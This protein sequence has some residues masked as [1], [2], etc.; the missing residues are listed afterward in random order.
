M[1][2][3]QGSQ[4]CDPRVWPLLTTDR[5]VESEAD[6]EQKD[7]STRKLPYRNTSVHKV[8]RYNTALQTPEGAIS[9]QRSG[10]TFPGSWNA[11]AWAVMGLTT[12]LHGASLLSCV[13]LL[14]PVTKIRTMM[15]LA[16]LRT[17][18]LCL[19]R[20]ERELVLLEETTILIQHGP[21]G[22]NGGPG[23]SSIH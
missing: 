16:R 20:K 8:L 3:E 4:A 10:V 18:L 9:P 7:T 5:N 23:L 14:Q 2:K 13:C 17:F 19:Q 11:W 12:L 1:A 15:S 21:C 6:N 22:G